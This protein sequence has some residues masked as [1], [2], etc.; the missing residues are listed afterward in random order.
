MPETL[1]P[2]SEIAKYAAAKGIIECADYLV[3]L[4]LPDKTIN[5]HRAFGEFKADM[6]AQALATMMLDDE[7][8]KALIDLAIAYH[9][10]KKSEE[11]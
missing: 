10:S 5:F 7:R 2:D 11:S 4:R 9:N 3:I 6:M 8:F 1:I